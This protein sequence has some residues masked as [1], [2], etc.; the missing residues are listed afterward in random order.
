MMMHPR[1]FRTM[2]SYD[3]LKPSTILI[4]HPLI[5]IFIAILLLSIVNFVT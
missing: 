2:K 3:L 1:F 4:F 5:S